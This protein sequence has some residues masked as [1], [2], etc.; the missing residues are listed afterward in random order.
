MDLLAADN[1]DA[2]IAGKVYDVG[3]TKPLQGAT[4]RIVG[5]ESGEAR[6]ATTDKEGC[7]SFKNVRAGG[8]SVSITYK[9]TEYLLAEKIKMENLGKVKAAIALCM[10]LQADKSLSMLENCQV[11]PKGIPVIAFIIAGGTAATVAGIVIGKS[12]TESSPTTP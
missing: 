4:V 7:Y 9:G 8:Y 12:G 3:Q 5:L 1:Q 10:A 6:V 11:C 2:Y